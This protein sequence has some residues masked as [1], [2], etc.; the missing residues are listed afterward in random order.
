MKHV[1]GES[2]EWKRTPGGDSSFWYL[3]FVVTLHSLL[4]MCRNQPRTGFDGAASQP[5]LSTQ[6]VPSAST[7][8]SPL[9]MIPSGA[10]RHT[11]LLPNVQHSR[12]ELPG[13]SM[14]DGK[15]LNLV[16]RCRPVDGSNW[17]DG[18][19]F[20]NERASSLMNRFRLG[21]RTLDLSTGKRFRNRSTY[22]NR[23]IVFRM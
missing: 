6:S 17:R 11:A 21:Q 12:R 9:R 19:Y 14:Q 23:P 16:V 20:I 5:G 22:L 1:G 4:T 18:H 7:R 15:V 13:G 10:I 3:G 8:K 2:N